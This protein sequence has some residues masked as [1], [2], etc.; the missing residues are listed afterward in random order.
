MEAKEN[1]NNS[2]SNNSNLLETILFKNDSTKILEV[3]SENPKRCYINI[4]GETKLQ[5]EEKDPPKKFILKISKKEFD[6]IQQPEKPEE[7]EKPDLSSFIQILQK[8]STTPNQYFQN[9]IYSKYS[10]IDLIQNKINIELIF[11]ATQKQIDKYKFITLE[12]FTETYSDYLS[13]T[14][15]YI[16]SLQ[17][18]DTTWIYNIFEKNVETPIGIAP[19]KNFWILKNYTVLDSKKKF[20]YLGIPV[21]KFDYIKSVRDLGKKELELLEEFLT[22]GK[23]ILEKETGVKKNEIRAFVHY[24]PAFYYLHIH[25]RWVNEL[26]DDSGIIN[27]AIDL[28]EIIE[29]I[30]LVGDYYQKISITHVVQVGSKLYQALNNGEKKDK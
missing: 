15:P 4:L 12:L 24:P 22:E 6:F 19:S 7:K 27:R 28:G 1:I 11:P 20:E 9:D 30:K 17:K 26:E 10:T 16:N 14:L 23:K 8:I 2:S 3:L 21:P 5:K 18:R 13:K 29:N 25:F